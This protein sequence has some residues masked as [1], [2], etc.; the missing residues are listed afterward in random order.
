MRLAQGTSPSR[1][2]NDA[3]H[4]E[5]VPVTAA[6]AAFACLAATKSGP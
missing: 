5:L 1:G 4:E 2:I 6:S 3:G